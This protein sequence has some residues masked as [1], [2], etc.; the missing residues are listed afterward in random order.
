MTESERLYWESQGRID[1]GPEEYPAEIGANGARCTDCGK[2]VAWRGNLWR[3]RRCR[4]CWIVA[5]CPGAVEPIPE[6][7]LREAV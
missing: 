5:G 3:G 2:M 7:L 1:F 4:K 6:Y